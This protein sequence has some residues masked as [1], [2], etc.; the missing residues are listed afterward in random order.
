MDNSRIEKEKKFWD[1][2][3]KRYDSFISHL[4]KSY[5]TLLE[6]II[7]N[8]NKEDIVL[9]IATGTGTLS[10]KIAKK[11]KKVIGIDIS[12]EMIKIANKKTEEYKTENVIFLTQDAYDINFPAEQFDVIIASNVLHVMVN[13]AKAINEI[14]RVLK[15]TGIFI[16]PTYCHGNNIITK[17]ISFF[18]SLIGFKAFHKWSMDSF[19][20]FIKENGFNI[21]ISKIIKDKIPLL[22]LVARKINK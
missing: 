17:V 7:N 15:K 18:M 8:L 20:L 16:A 14:K 10:I 21:I 11:V 4:D 13:P 3:A 2:F 5:T 22:F 1:S 9:E 6:N 12:E 19:K